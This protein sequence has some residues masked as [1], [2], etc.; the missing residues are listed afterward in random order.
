MYYYHYVQEWT[1]VE[2]VCRCL[3]VPVG[4]FLQTVEISLIWEISYVSFIL[5]SARHSTA[6][7]L[8]SYT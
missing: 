4:N 8:Y 1:V 2:G 6:V 5:V 3:Q 7:Q